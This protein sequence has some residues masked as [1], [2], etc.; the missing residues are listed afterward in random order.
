[1]IHSY[2]EESDGNPRLTFEKPKDGNNNKLMSTLGLYNYYGDVR[3]KNGQTVYVKWDVNVVKEQNTCISGAKRAN[4]IPYNN[5]IV[6][7]QFVVYSI[8]IQLT[9]GEY[10]SLPIESY[11]I[12][13]SSI[14][15]VGRHGLDDE[16]D[17]FIENDGNDANLVALPRI[18]IQ[19]VH[20]D[21]NNKLA[22]IYV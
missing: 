19:S 8:E 5:P 15:G 16:P 10:V 17:P 9:N 20:Y 21:F 3:C 11:K 6:K 2:F 12:V 22:I 18:V 13:Y 1:M 4:G 7:V 14:D